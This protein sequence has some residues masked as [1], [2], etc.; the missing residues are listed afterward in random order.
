MHFAFDLHNQMEKLFSELVS[1]FSLKVKMAKS[2][3]ML[4]QLLY[5]FCTTPTIF[6]FFLKLT[7]VY[8][9]PTCRKRDPIVSLKKRKKKK[10]LELYNSCI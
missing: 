8:V 3:G 10:M 2:L 1:H 4:L 6:F 7:I 9:G 5:N